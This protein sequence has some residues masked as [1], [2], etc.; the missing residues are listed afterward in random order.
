MAVRS[1]PLEGEDEEEEFCA[2]QV[3]AMRK[4]PARGA[5]VLS[6]IVALELLED[7]IA[8]ILHILMDSD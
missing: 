5:N 7:H 6:C 4:A 3:S 8:E 1:I 2:L